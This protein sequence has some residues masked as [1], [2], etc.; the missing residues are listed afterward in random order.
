MDKGRMAVER[1]LFHSRL[2]PP[3]KP[4]SFSPKPS[5]ETEPIPDFVLLPSPSSGDRP[6]ISP[7]SAF[8]PGALG[9]LI[10]CIDP[11]GRR[12]GQRVQACVRRGRG[13][14]PAVK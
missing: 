4:M 2:S 5:P 8:R 10:N 1:T 14:P 12:S 3:S 11:A 13:R 9:S 6:D 7:A